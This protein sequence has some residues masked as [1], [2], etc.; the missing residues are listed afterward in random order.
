MIRHSIV[1]MAGLL[2][3]ALLLLA[4]LAPMAAAGKYA[5]L[6]GGYGDAPNKNGLSFMWKTLVNR[7]GYA[8]TDVYVLW[9]NGTGLDLNGDG[10]NDPCR[11]ATRANIF[12]VFDTL[13]FIKDVDQDDVV[14][15]YG[16]DHGTR[17]LNTNEPGLCLY[18]DYEYLWA[19]EVDSLFTNLEDE[20]VIDYWPKL[21]AM[22]D[23]C[24]SGGFVDSMIPYCKRAVCSAAK[25]DQESYAA[26]GTRPDPTGKYASINYTTFSY[27]WIAAMNGANP[28]GVVV[29]ADA[30]ADGCVSFKEAFDYAAAN[31]E[32]AKDKNSNPQYWDFDE[33][34]GKLTT[35]DGFPIPQNQTG[36]DRGSTN[37]ALAGG[38]S[39]WGD[40]GTGHRFG[41]GF[42]FTLPIGA[43]ASATPTG[44]ADIR[45]GQAFL[46]VRN[47]GNEPVT[48]SVVHFFYGAPST[49]ASVS[50][51]SLQP[52]ATV[53]LG[54]LGPGD[55]VL[56]GPV[57]LPTL[58]PNPY[59]QSHWKLLAVVEGPQ[60]PLES[61][62]VS[63]D[64]HVA[65]ENY[66]RD[67]SLTGGPVDLYYRVV[68]PESEPRRIFL[69]LAQNT[70]PPG[71]SVESVPAL[72]E[73]LNVAPGAI[74]TA[75]LRVWP[76][77]VHGPGGIVTVEEELL[78][79]FAGC[80]V[81][82]LGGEDSTFITEGGYLRTTGGIR[83]KVTAPYTL[84]VPQERP[85]LQMSLAYP[86]P[87]TGQVRLAYSLPFSSPVRISVHDIAGRCLLQR[88]L[89]EQGSGRHTFV[90]DGKD[91]R[92][93][94]VPTGVYLLRLE[95]R[96]LAEER[97]VVV[98]R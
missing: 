60:S 96:E 84:S 64:K 47:T 7:Y 6:I 51:T 90:W 57:T 29:N 2:A 5:V 19:H 66:Y 82:C 78:G 77:L 97:R 22:F 71:W 92:G 61:G 12:A 58:G 87:S 67:S 38:V 68:N 80:K 27:H 88:E 13:D 10:I 81:S 73:S 32:Y 76:D 79:T 89:G 70:L 95:T 44:N 15:L 36:S 40:G 91:G 46:R 39:A 94:P 21:L 23:Q 43:P 42:L 37:H 62:W 34:F 74:L 85:G 65:V 14:F 45:G 17:A 1:F 16:D 48:G 52:F 9:N 63:D 86:N 28:E 83:F 54:T 56:A 25:A 53:P 98:V 75:R 50:D 55:S 33:G 4:G 93:S 72:G 8:P 24:W 69:K 20:D 35:L 41:S 3:G 26:T 18:W 30:N 31:D 59:G 11:A 49:I